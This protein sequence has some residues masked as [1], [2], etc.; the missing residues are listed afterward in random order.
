VDC[1]LLV[2]LG[3]EDSGP[4]RCDT[5]RIQVFVPRRVNPDLSATDRAPSCARPANLTGGQIVHRCLDREPKY[6]AAR[7]LARLLRA[8]AHLPKIASPRSS[9]S[10]DTNRTGAMLSVT[11]RVVITATFGGSSKGQ[12]FGA[13]GIVIPPRV[14]EVTLQSTTS[15]KLNKAKKTVRSPR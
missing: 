2:V 9:L 14:I 8:A 4:S 7:L 5:R 11:R 13:V 6:A 15:R 12:S 3:W 1:S 10:R